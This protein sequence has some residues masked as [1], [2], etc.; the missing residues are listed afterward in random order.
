MILPRKII[1]LKKH[2]NQGRFTHLK[3]RSTHLQEPC[4]WVEHYLDLKVLWIELEHILQLKVDFEFQLCSRSG[5]F[6]YCV[7]GVTRAAISVTVG[8]L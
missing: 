7:L 4:E 2:S 8:R 5:L 1:Q 3:I 6:G